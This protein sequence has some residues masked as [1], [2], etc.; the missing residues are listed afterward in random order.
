M[1]GEDDVYDK[2]IEMGETGDFRWTVF[3]NSTQ[4]Y[5]V[6]VNL[7]GGLTTWKNDISPSYFVLS[8]DRPYEII[9]LTITVPEYPDD[10]VLKGT[11][12]FRFRELNT[13]EHIT[14][15]KNVTAR[16][17]G[18]DKVK[19]SNR[20]VGDF[21][22]PLPPPLDGPYGAFIL[23]VLIWLLIALFISVLI[24]PVIHS[25]ARKTE[26]QLDDLMVRLIRKPILILI[27]LYGLIDSVLTLNLTLGIQTTIYRVYMLIV[28]IIGVYVAYRILQ[29]VLEEITRKKGGEETAFGQV[30]KPVLEKVIAVVILIGG[31]IIGLRMM[32]IEVTALLA[33]AG[34][35]GLV[36]AF[37]AQDTLSNFFSGMHLLL[38][39]PF[40]MGDVIRLEGGEY[41]EVKEIG[42]RSTKLYS[43]FDHEQIIL[44][45]NSIANQKIINIVQPDTHIRAKVEVGV[46]YGSDLKKVKE[47]LM[48]VAKDHPNVLDEGKFEPIIRFKEFGDSS[49]N[50]SLRFWVDDYMNQW[51]VTSD[52]R[53]EIDK[54]FRESDVTIPFPQTTVWLNQQD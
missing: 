22:N 1:V 19:K 45:N 10:E 54:R 52:I 51:K 48:D 36:I 15:K 18:A 25:F 49:L 41:C 43:I 24:G 37:A 27:F 20:I 35:M 11:V 23:N 7:T 38:D 3:K 42:L 50:F 53:D 17:E 9:V 6:K 32:G 34:V 21:Q 4:D 39:R 16:V 26:T 14:I 40:T 2:S 47:I 44:P 28:V 29:G 30:L 8:E 5:S 46:A 31:L 12:S 33:G 13:T